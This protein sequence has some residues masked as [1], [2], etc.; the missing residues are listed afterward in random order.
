MRLAQKVAMLSRVTKALLR[1]RDPVPPLTALNEAAVAAVY[2]HLL[3]QIE[4]EI[5]ET[6]DTEVRKAMRVVLEKEFAQQGIDLPNATCP[7]MDEW[8]FLTECCMDRILWD[9]DYDDFADLMDAPPDK[10][11]AMRKLLS[12]DRNY[13]TAIPPDPSEGEFKK[14]LRSLNRLLLAK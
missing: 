1:K 6:G 14:Q 2:G 5:D 9:R 10:A 11:A 12:I 3:E 8:H 7:E 13:Y 4:C